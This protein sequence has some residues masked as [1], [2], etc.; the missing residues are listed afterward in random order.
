MILMI[1]GTLSGSS[2]MVNTNS[3]SIVATA[4]L[5]RNPNPPEVCEIVER[6]ALDMGIAK[7]NC[8]ELT[9]NRVA[10]LLGRREAGE[11]RQ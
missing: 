3:H 1:H 9:T 11:G 8:H 4:M 6:L 2:I 10:A 7:D 5:G